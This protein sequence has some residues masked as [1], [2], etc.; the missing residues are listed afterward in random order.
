MH[1][2]KAAFI[3]N[4][5][6][7]RMAILVWL[8]RMFP[9]GMN[10]SFAHL[11]VASSSTHKNREKILNVGTDFHNSL[12]SAQPNICSSGVFIY[13]DDVATPTW[14]GRYET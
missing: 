14:I 12:Y 10:S 2:V 8:S 4:N 7:S 1:L 13:A 3:N 5:N 6:H 9:K 11:G